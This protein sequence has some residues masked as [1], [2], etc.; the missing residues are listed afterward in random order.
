MPESAG[1]DAVESSSWL[2]DEII[3]C[4]CPRCGAPMSIRM[5]LKVADCFRCG[6]SIEITEEWTRQV[7]G[8]TQPP[9]LPIDP[10]PPVRETTGKKVAAA[11]QP[12]G[13]RRKIRDLANEG[14]V[15]V[16][17]L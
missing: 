6:T 11:L 2:T 5:W 15:R 8:T 13:V 3:A 17:W 12:I 1:P 4:G 14:S 9:A 10:V 7:S 16:W